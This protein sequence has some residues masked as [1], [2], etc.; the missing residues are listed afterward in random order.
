MKMGKSFGPYR[1]YNIWLL[2][3]L[4]TSFRRQT[5]WNRIIYPDPYKVID[6]VISKQISQ[7]N[8]LEA[9]LA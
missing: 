9:K 2:F 5:F 6:H 7:K 8:I 1:L 4:R 3:I